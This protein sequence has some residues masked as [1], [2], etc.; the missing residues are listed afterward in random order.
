MDSVEVAF[1]NVNQEFVRLDQL[2]GK[3][4]I[5]GTIW[6][7]LWILFILVILMFVAFVYL[8]VGLFVVRAE[9]REAEEATS[10]AGDAES[11]TRA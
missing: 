2:E 11:A 3:D 5:L 1:S 4:S 8:A 6:D 9:D 10:E 7:I